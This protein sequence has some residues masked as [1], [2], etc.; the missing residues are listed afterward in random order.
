MVMEDWLAMVFF[1]PEMC[2]G[3]PHCTSHKETVEDIIT[4]KRRLDYYSNELVDLMTK[5]LI[6]YET[7]LE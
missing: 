4:S 1:L 6:N 2:A 7:S 3:V 5:F